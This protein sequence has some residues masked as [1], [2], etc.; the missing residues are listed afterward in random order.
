M[1]IPVLQ[2]VDRTSVLWKGVKYLFFGGYDYHR[3][4]SLPEV[5]SAFQQSAKE[6]G[7]NSGGSLCTTGTHPFHK[8]LEKEIGRFIGFEAVALFPSCY[9]ANQALIYYF[10]NY[11]YDIFYPEKSHPSLNPNVNGKSYSYSKLEKLESSIEKTENPLIIA[12]SIINHGNEI[13]PL[14]VMMRRIPQAHFLIDDAHGIGV[15]GEKGRGI[16]EH[17][18][19]DKSNIIYS[20]SLSKGIG[21]FGGFITGSE[22]FIEK[23]KNT[24]P[25]YQGSSALPIPV[26]ASAIKSMQIL[27]NK[28]EMIIKLKKTAISFKNS[29]ITEG[30]KIPLSETPVSALNITD[31]IKVKKVKENLVKNRIFPSLIHYPGS[32]NCGIFRFALS[33][34][35]SQDQIDTLLSVLLSTL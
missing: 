33:S 25:I 7:I 31:N 23:V 19:L 35:H 26:C 24:S 30:I 32:P 4:S 17:F 8:K 9:L 2:S 15:I 10:N 5:I 29:L 21:V 27:T 16:C 22:Q 13:A 18:K 14:D 3:H 34:V 6:F 12:E 1:D 28:P 11:N 20:G